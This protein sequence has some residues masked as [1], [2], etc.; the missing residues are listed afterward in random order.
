MIWRIDWCILFVDWNDPF[1]W[2]KFV[3]GPPIVSP[4]LLTVGRKNDWSDRFRTGTERKKMVTSEFYENDLPQKIDL[5]WEKI[6][7][8]KRYLLG[9]PG[10]KQ[11][12]QTDEPERVNKCF[13]EKDRLSWSD[14]GGVLFS[15]IRLTTTA[16]SSRFWKWSTPSNPNRRLPRSSTISKRSSRIFS[17]FLYLTPC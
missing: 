10:K 6:D 7:Q 11:S 1:R 5:F 17:L 16:I 14:Q 8:I 13:R 2:V 9:Y 4:V 15:G 3:S 12:A